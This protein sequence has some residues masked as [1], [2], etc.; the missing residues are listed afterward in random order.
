[1]KTFKTKPCKKCSVVFQPKSTCNLYCDTCA[2]IALQETKKRG[3][4]AFYRRQGRQVGVGS[5][6]T[7]GFGEANPYYKHG[8]SVFD[9]WAREK[10]AE[11]GKCER[12][13]CEIDRTKRG[14]WAGHHKDHNPNNNVKE[15]LELLCRRCHAIEHECWKAFE[16][17]TTKVTRDKVTG[18]FKRIEA[19]DNQNG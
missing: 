8:K 10:L 7:T 2:P 15:N 5:G 14:S 17:A 6:G 4:D 9:R 12:C 19:P 11:I 16:G 3:R 13:S 18:R 1:M